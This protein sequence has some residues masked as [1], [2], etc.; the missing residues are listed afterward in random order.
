MAGPPLTKHSM[1]QECP[2]SD[3]ALAICHPGR[4]VRAGAAGNRG[5]TAQP[6]TQEEKRADREQC[7][8]LS[9]L[10]LLSLCTV[11][12]EGQREEPGTSAR[13][14]RQ[15][16]PWHPGL[17]IAMHGLFLRVRQLGVL[18]SLTFSKDR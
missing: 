15:L 18:N 8:E 14:Q 17:S 7:E 1:S 11:S 10:L 12:G 5:L 2:S 6:G 16:L 13:T 4:A 9:R 3:P